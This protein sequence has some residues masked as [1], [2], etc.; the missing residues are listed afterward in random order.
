MLRS[1]QLNQAIKADIEAGS[2]VVKE[3]EPRQG[4]SCYHR[5]GGGYMSRGLGKLEKSILAILAERKD[6]KE[7]LY[8]LVR[9]LHFDT[10]KVLAGEVSDRELS[11]YKPS[12]SSYQS[13]ARALRSLEKKRLVTSVVKPE[14]HMGQRGLTHWKEITLISV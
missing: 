13:V 11:E 10:A 1:G 2:D 3:W 12:Q 7:E 5:K 8:S 9:E 6:K 14:M 4:G